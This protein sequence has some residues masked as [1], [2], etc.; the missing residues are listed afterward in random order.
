M[1]RQLTL[2]ERHDRLWKAI[3]LA[4]EK[5]ERR[6]DFNAD[7]DHIGALMSELSH[8]VEA[9]EGGADDTTHDDYDRVEQRLDALLSDLEGS[10]GRA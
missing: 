3:R 4:S 8:D 2:A 1:A 10:H 9:L 5:A 6:R 7:E